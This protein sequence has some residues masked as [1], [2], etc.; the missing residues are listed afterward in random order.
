MAMELGLALREEP[1]LRVF[2]NKV[3]KKIFGTKRDEISRE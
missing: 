1:R 3:L 2:K